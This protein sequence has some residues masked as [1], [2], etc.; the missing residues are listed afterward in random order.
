MNGACHALR[1]RNTNKSHS[2]NKK[3]P[4]FEQKKNR[5]IE[6][7]E[8]NKNDEGKNEIFLYSILFSYH[9]S[10]FRSKKCYGSININD[11]ERRCLVYLNSS[12]A[13]GIERSHWLN[14]GY[15]KTKWIR[16]NWQTESTLTHVQ[17]TN[18]LWLTN[19]TST[20]FA[21][22]F[23]ARAF[24]ERFSNQC[25]LKVK[26]SW[27]RIFN[28]SGGGGSGNRIPYYPRTVFIAA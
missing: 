26:Y 1:Q 13:I 11:N 14:K 18:Y 5:W 20:F 12:N 27:Y 16:W 17:Q 4:S 7:F 8:H 6:H 10:I 23:N 2:F 24:F 3:F 9:L 19:F 15:K 21:S 22:P 28:G 25:S